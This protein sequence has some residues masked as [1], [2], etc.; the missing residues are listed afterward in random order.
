MA[1][2][3]A[4]GYEHEF[5]VSTA[6]LKEFECPLCL[7]VTREPHLTDCCGQHFCQAC[8]NRIVTDRKPCPFCKADSFIVIL[9]KK[10][11]RRVLELIVECTMKERG[12]DWSGELGKLDTHVGTRNVSCQ[13]VDVNCPNNCGES[14]QR[15]HLANHLSNLC[16]NDPSP[17]YTA[18]SKL[19]M[20]RFAM[21][22]IR[23]V[24]STQFPVPTSVRLEQSN[25]ATWSNT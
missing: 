21:I 10:Q 18:S 7:F 2:S 11:K 8:I 1:S 19:R 15:R 13:F 20:N 5:L 17:A 23:S 12:C 4:G 3:N 24:S 14:H 6:K 25:E 9:D 22:T 16:P